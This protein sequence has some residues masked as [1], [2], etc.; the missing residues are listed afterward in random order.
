MASAHSSHMARSLRAFGLSGSL[1]GAPP[2]ATARLIRID[3][4]LHLAHQH[5]ED[6]ALALDSL[7]QALELFE[8]A[9]PANELPL[10]SRPQRS[11]NSSSLRLKLR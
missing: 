3:L 5:A 10:R 11:T 6:R 9:M 4:A 8:Y 7:A 1:A 2:A